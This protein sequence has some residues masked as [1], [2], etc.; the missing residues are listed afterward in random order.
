MVL[1]ELCGE[2]FSSRIT[3]M[4]ACAR[5]RPGSPSPTHA[6][7]Y[8]EAPAGRAVRRLRSPRRGAGYSAEVVA[9]VQVLDESRLDRPPAEQLAGQRGGSRLVAREDPAQEAEIL[10]RNGSRRQIQV[11]A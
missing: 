10:G 1:P 3:R 4:W 6:R 11:A 8:P 2:E 9:L 7:R 5:R